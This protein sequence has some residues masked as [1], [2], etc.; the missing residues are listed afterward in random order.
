MFAPLYRMRKK[1]DPA[2]MMKTAL[3]HS[4]NGATRVEPVWDDHVVAPLIRAIQWLSQRIQW[5]Q[6]GDFRLYCLYVVA[7]LVTLLIIAAI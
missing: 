5:L 7:A 2:P 1:L 3:E 4:V 6:Q